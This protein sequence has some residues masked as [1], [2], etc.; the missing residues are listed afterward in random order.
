[1]TCSPPTTLLPLPYVYRSVYLLNQQSTRQ[2]SA[3]CLVI[4]N[5][6]LDVIEDRARYD[7]P[8]IECKDIQILSENCHPCIA[9]RATWN[10]KGINVRSTPLALDILCE[11]MAGG[12][13]EGYNL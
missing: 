9:S 1:M 5:M 3:C 7:S 13:I 2:S 6:V 11:L 8:S 12:G 4:H 10:G